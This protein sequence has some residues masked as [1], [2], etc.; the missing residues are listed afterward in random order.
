MDQEIQT[1]TEQQQKTVAVDVF[2]ADWTFERFSDEE[3]R[4]YQIRTNGSDAFE[5]APLTLAEFVSLF[6]HVGSDDVTVSIGDSFGEVASDDPQD[7]LN[8][9]YG[10]WNAGGLSFGESAAFKD[11]KVRSLSVGDVIQ[12]GDNLYMVDRFGFGQIDFAPA[13]GGR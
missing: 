10:R 1:Q 11:A 4:V 5:D 8:Y 2:H 6:D 13:G 12:I 3:E 7:V 9:V